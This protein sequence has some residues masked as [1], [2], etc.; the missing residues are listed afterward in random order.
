MLFSQRFVATCDV[1]QHAKHD[2]TT[3][4]GLLQP[5]PILEN[6]WEEIFMDFIEGLPKVQG[7]SVIF[8]VVDRLSKYA[9][10]CT[11]SHPYTAKHVAE[12]FMH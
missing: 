3:P 4:A 1:C 11:L 2:S 8:V 10:F 12:V 6:V 7:Q 5:L 9:H